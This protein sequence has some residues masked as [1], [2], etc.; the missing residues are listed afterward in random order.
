M[1]SG[2]VGV[3]SLSCIAMLVSLQA[4]ENLFREAV[5]DPGPSVSWTVVFI[6]ALVIIYYS[7]SFRRMFQNHLGLKRIVTQMI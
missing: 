5:M 3:S 6:D 2:V 7:V 4:C 1:A